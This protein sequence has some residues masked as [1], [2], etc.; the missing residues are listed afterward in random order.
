MAYV[1]EYAF[2]EREGFRTQSSDKPSNLH[3]SSAYECN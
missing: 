2:E 1:R 3:D